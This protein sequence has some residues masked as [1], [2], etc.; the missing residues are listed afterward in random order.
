MKPL[1]LALVACSLVAPKTA[2][3]KTPT[4]QD[5][6]GKQEH[7]MANCPSTVPTA[8]TSIADSKGGVALTITGANAA[9]VTEIQRRAGVQV[10]IAVQPERGAIE[11]TGDGT[12]SG[13]LGYCPGMEQGSVMTVDNLPDGARIVVLAHNRA[14]VAGLRQRTRDRLGRLEA[15][16]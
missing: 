16:R 14:D 10:N 15:K 11:H 8:K 13:E 7:K 5:M 1:A 3:A 9:A 6:T 4:S 2:S 12:G